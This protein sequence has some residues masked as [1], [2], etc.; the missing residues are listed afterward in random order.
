MKEQKTGK[1]GSCIA[2]STQ[3][4]TFA[5]RG[6]ATHRLAQRCS[7]VNNSTRTADSWIG[8]KGK[9]KK[10]RKL[11]KEVKSVPQKTEKK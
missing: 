5:S 8:K 3:H 2:V 4:T 9:R 6:A 11:P 10:K 1:T 7:T